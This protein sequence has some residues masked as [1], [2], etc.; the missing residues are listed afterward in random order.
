MANDQRWHMRIGEVA[1]LTGLPLRSIRHYEDAGLVAPSACSRGGLHLYT[2]ADVERLG[3]VR[4]MRRLEFTLDEIRELL[5]IVDRIA[6]VDDP[7]GDE[8]L[9][10][11]RARLEVYR[12]TVD[13]RCAVLGARLR[14]AED[15]AATLRAVADHLDHDRV[16]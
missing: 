9:E 10:T 15:F 16:G 3:V 8:E 11:L 13:T 2:P 4:R 1:E 12:R 6:V 7:P 5:G 14:E